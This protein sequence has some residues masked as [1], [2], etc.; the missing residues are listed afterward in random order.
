ATFL[1]G[2]RSDSGQGIAVDGAGAAYITGE[3][4]SADFPT[5]PSAFD[6]S[7]NGGW[8]AFVAKLNAGGT[9]LHYATFLGGGGGDKG[10]AIAVDGAGGAYVTGWTTSTDFPT[11][12]APSIPATT[13]APPL[14]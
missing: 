7:F 9:T 5:T 14:W 10:H 8:D 12:P 2:S 11:T 1:G 4:G 3:T 6:P 13:A